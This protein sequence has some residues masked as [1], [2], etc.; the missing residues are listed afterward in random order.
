[1][2]EHN[3]FANRI[4]QN[5]D[6][7]KTE[8]QTRTKSSKLEP[9]SALEVT[10]SSYFNQNSFILSYKTNTFNHLTGMQNLTSKVD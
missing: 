6:G 10:W 3:A 9:S 4:P 8:E 1:M 5:W 7:T 2:A